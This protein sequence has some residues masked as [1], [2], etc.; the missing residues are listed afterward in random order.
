VLFLRFRLF[1]GW[2]RGEN[3]VRV[4]KVLMAVLG[5][6]RETVVVAWAL[7]EG[8]RPRVEV[9]LRLKA[10][11]R[12]RCGRC[13]EL[14]SFYDQGGGE[15][16]WRHVDVGFATCE[17]IADARRV[18][19]PEH[20]PTVAA[21]PWARH[22]S[23]FSRAF[24]DLVVHDAIVGN[25]QAA[26]D[27]YGVSWRAVN[28]MCVRVATEALGRVDLLD[29]LVAIA[30]DEV[31]YKKGQRYLTFV[32]DHVTG[33]VVWAAKGRSKATVGEFFDALGDERAAALQFVT[34]D[35]AEWIRTV[36][37]ERAAEAIVCLDTFHV[38]SWA[39]DALDEVRRGEWNQLRR[40]GGAAAAKTLKGLRFLLLRNWENLTGAQRA[41]IRALDSSN[42]RLLRG[43]QLKEELRDIFTLPLLAAR[44]A[45]D[46]WLA[47]A[48][49]SRLAPFVK[50]A[51]TIR[52]YRASIEATIEWKLTNGIAES[53]NAAIGR[54]RA[55]ARGFHDPDAFMTMI[56]LDRAG[57]APRLPWS[58]V[59]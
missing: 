54:I 28:N 35:G 43:W 26:A 36:V 51:R 16:R 47:Y 6:C 40:S 42:R 23:A 4:K 20:G 8:D 3:G 30:I 18:D 39:T 58:T 48:S 49:R 44:R 9:W 22:D 25:K 52:A 15:R 34:A 45:L 33:K 21:V 31:K 53:N 14:A 27:R 10:R 2:R 55:N 11:R 29:G 59:A 12:G 17:L 46:D 5:L 56:L 7:A 32:C 57:I 38:I 19:C 50:L 13:G 37:A 24:E 41:T 1:E